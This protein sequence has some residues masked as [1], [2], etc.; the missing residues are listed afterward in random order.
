M[1][2]FY[3]ILY[4]IFFCVFG[5]VD[6]FTIPSIICFHCFILSSFVDSCIL[7]DVFSWNF[8]SIWFG[9]LLA[10][11]WIFLISFCPCFLF[12]SNYISSDV[13]RAMMTCHWLCIISTWNP[14]LRVTFYYIPSLYW[15]S[16]FIYLIAVHF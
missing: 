2:I 6:N 12:V 16:D 8:F 1:Q 4:L 5:F 13:K 15:S 14:T 3:Y 11:R 9:I 10:L 7:L